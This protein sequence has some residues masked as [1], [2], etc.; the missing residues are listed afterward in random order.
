MLTPLA[1]AV[2]DIHRRRADKKLVAAVEDF[3]EH[4]IPG[5]FQGSEP[6]IYLARHVATPSFETVRFMELARPYDLPIVISQD[7]KDKFV[8]HNSMKRALGKMPV[9]KGLDHD[10]HEIIEYFTIVDF[11]TDQGK[12]LEDIVTS[13]GEPLVQFHNKL[14]RKLYSVDE[15]ILADDSAWIDRKGR[16]R[17]FEHYKQFLSLYIV[18]GVM[19]ESYIDEDDPFVQNILKPTFALT[20]ERFGVR[21]L[22]ANLVDDEL[23][24]TRNWYSYPPEIYGS[25]EILQ[26]PLQTSTPFTSGIMHRSK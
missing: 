10:R 4:D 26:K 14:L 9:V 21:P 25:I 20:E 13:F 17:L 23:L 15:V 16:G 11:A 12:H 22:I 19:L 8:S 5:Y 18:H 7:P 2:E 6:V 24:P 1:K 3:L